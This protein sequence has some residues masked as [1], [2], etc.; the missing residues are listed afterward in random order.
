MTKKKEDIKVVEPNQLS[1]IQVATM[2]DGEKVVIVAPAEGGFLVVNESEM[3]LM[4]GVTYK[5]RVWF[6]PT[7]DMVV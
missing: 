4:D 3:V 1:T 2:K 6:V 7:K 5:R